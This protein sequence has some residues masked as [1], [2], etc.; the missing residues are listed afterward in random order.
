MTC[1]SEVLKFKE[2]ER[3]KFVDCGDGVRF[4]HR[5]RNLGEK[6]EVGRKLVESLT[7]K[8]SWLDGGES[9]SRNG[10]EN[11]RGHTK[12][13]VGLAE[14]AVISKLECSSSWDPHGKWI[15]VEIPCIPERSSHMASFPVQPPLSKEVGD[16]SETVVEEYSRV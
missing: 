7:F 11:L 12:S 3:G 5:L 15:L 16:S 2:H 4:V 8:N 10:A 1:C 13:L 9:G 6:L 14:L